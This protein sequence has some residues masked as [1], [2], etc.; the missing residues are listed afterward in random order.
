MKKD[1]S[2]R[3]LLEGIHILEYR[4]RFHY[5]NL[6]Q[7][8]LQHSQEYHMLVLSILKKVYKFTF[9]STS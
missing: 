9:G 4:G 5:R 1:L 3:I 2:V 7:D 6:V 8:S